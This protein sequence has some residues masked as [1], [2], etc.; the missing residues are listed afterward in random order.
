MK[1]KKLFL[2]AA[3]L[4]TSMC[5]FAQGENNEPLKGDVNGDGKVDVAD[6]TA[7]VKIIMENGGTSEPTKYYWYA[8]TTPV[9][10]DNYQQIASQV[11]SYENEYYVTTTSRTYIYILVASN[12]NVT[13]IEPTLN[14]PIDLIE[15]TDINIPNHTIYRSY[16]KCMGENIQIRISDGVSPTPEA[17]YY[18]YVG[19]T[20]PSDPTNSDENTDTNK[21]TQINSTPNSLHVVSP[22]ISIGTWYV[23]IPHE[24]G[25]QAYDTSG[26]VPDTAAYFKSN[27]TINNMLYDLFTTANVAVQVNSIFKK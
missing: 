1:T 9:T 16:G 15:M 18:W 23:A 22:Q 6:I 24:Y 27:I 2:M 12:K 7:I 4:L 3:M 14:A 19:T 5:A 10:T 20:L 13:L 21:W 17:T 26:S 25:F 11:T 8:G